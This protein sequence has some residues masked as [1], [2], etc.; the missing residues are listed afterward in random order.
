MGLE[1]MYNYFDFVRAVSVKDYGLSFA[2]DVCHFVLAYNKWRNDVLDI[3]G[4]GSDLSDIIFFYGL[5]DYGNDRRSLMSYVFDNNDLS[6]AVEICSS[7][8]RVMIYMKCDLVDFSIF[9]EFN[10]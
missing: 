7:I 10:K 4:Y 1:A 2:N 3:N 9:N 5:D 6:D 8:S